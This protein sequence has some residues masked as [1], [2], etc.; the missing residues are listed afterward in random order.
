V[1]A[2]VFPVGIGIAEDEAT[3]AAAQR[4]AARLDRPIEIRQGRASRIQ[5]RPRDAGWVEIGGRSVL[6]EVREYAVP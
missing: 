6:D 5:A 4:L 1:G 3:G 2:R